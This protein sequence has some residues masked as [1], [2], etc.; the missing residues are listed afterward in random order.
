MRAARA[1]GRAVVE[2][3]P[4]GRVQHWRRRLLGLERLGALEQFWLVGWLDAA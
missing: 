1:A 3:L 4:P 2:V